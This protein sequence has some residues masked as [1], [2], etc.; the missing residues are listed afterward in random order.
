M[1]KID[2]EKMKEL[3]IKKIEEGYK[4]IEELNI[5]DKDC[6]T[7]IVNVF[8]LEK[9]INDL[10]AKTA[11]DEEMARKEKNWKRADEIR[12]ELSSKNVLIEDTP[13]GTKYTFK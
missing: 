3:C 13:T 6:V 9:T 8:E 12:N 7:A 11:Y 4:V 10:D 2:R 1:F 5:R